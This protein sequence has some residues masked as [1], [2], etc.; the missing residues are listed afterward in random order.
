VPYFSDVPADHVFFKWVQ[1]FRELGMTVGC[2]PNS[3]CP[4]D[5]MTRGQAS[6]FLAR[7]FLN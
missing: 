5:P 3:F 1:K 4:D 7:A 6:R 2:A